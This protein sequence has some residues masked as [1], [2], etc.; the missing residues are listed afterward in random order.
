MMAT[1]AD[2]GLNNP[3][4]LVLNTEVVLMTVQSEP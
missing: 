4:A 2:S 3:L 1:A